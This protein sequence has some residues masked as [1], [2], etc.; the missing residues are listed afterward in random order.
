MNEQNTGSFT[1]ARNLVLDKVKDLEQITFDLSFLNP[2][3]FYL[4]FINTIST[5]MLLGFTRFL[6]KKSFLVELFGLKFSLFAAT[7]SLVSLSFITISLLF[8]HDKKRK[9]G[10]SLFEVISDKMQLLKVIEN[11]ATD[12]SSVGVSDETE[13][14]SKIRVTLR[15]F[16]QKEDLLLASSKIGASVYSAVNI[17]LVFCLA[18]LN[19]LILNSCL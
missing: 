5:A 3:I 10:D 2:V 13:F 17:S 11:T 9:Y 19:R 16:T 14:V 18:S 4:T 6:A 7:L 15:T 8:L 1:A 12:S